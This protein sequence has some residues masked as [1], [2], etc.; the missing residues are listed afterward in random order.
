M[1]VN[2]LQ[3]LFVGII[4]ENSTLNDKAL[5]DT[6]LPILKSLGRK[7]MKDGVPQDGNKAELS[8]LVEK[9]SHF[10]NNELEQFKLLKIL[11]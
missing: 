3:I 7:V 11:N 10:L 5:A 1:Q 9:A 6:C 2:L 4:N 8:A